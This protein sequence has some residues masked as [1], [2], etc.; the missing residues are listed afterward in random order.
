MMARYTVTNR[1]SVA[2]RPA[3]EANE[4]AALDAP[5][6]RHH[7]RWVRR[8]LH[9]GDPIIYSLDV[10][11]RPAT[12]A[13]STE[14]DWSGSCSLTCSSTMNGM[15]S[16]LWRD[17]CGLLPDAGRSGGRGGDRREDVLDPARS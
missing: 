6:V 14:I 10:I 9:R 7:P 15:P 16:P 11:P 3:S 13:I 5:P 1:A 4:A 17:P 8:G 2:V 12:W